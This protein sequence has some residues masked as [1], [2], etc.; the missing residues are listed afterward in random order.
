MGRV[1]QTLV[2]EVAQPLRMQGQYYDPE[3]DLCYNRYRYFDPQSCTFISQDPLGLAA[4][5]NVY[6]YGPNVWMW[7]D[8]LG[9][10]CEDG[11]TK[12]IGKIHAYSPESLGQRSPHFTVETI[13][14]TRMH[15]H[16]VVDIDTKL[17]TMDHATGLPKPTST[18]TVELADI[19]AAQRLQK[20]RLGAELGTYNIRKNSCLTNA[21]DVLREG[22]ADIPG[23]GKELIEWTQNVFK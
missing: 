22:G 6:A 3:I 2:D 18:Y 10:K 13:G 17:T 8:P 14:E 12:G 19:D 16:Q 9:L 11:S 20:S 15:T 21:C 7:A 5:E 4:G 23:S 1:D